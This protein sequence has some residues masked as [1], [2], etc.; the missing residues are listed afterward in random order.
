MR[1]RLRS[2]DPKIAAES[3][4]AH[5]SAYKMERKRRGD[6][7]HLDKRGDL[8]E[9]AV[10]ELAMGVDT[11]RVSV[12]AELGRRRELL[13][14]DLAREAR[15]LDAVVLCRPRTREHGDGGT[16]KWVYAHRVEFIL[17]FE[18]EAAALAARVV[19]GFKVVVREVLLGYRE[20]AAA[21]ARVLVG[22]VLRR[23]RRQ[24]EATSDRARG[25][26]HG[27]EVAAVEET[28]AAAWT[29]RVVRGRAVVLGE[30]CGARAARIAEL[31]VDEGHV[32]NVVHLVR[33]GF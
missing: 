23:R 15:V 29:V 24:S 22:R 27:V 19:N 1:P 7:T 33:V 3:R 28:C 17:V 26:T 25:N 21:H 2:P 9:W 10:A 20:P 31:A 32:Q 8:S 11:R 6:G 13:V 30:A 14:A 4:I 12:S 5:P 16:E 18:P